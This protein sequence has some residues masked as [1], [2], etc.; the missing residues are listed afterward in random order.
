MADWAGSVLAGGC[1]GPRGD[2]GDI[3]LAA[4]RHARPVASCHVRVVYRRRCNV[5]VLPAR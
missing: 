1:A 3:R 5:Q 2:L 4:A